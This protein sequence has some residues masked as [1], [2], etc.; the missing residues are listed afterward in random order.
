M[1]EVRFMPA[2]QP[3]QKGPMTAAEHRAQMV[4][5]AIAGEPRFALDM[6]E[7]ERGGPTYTI[8]TL[9]VQLRSALPDCA[10]GADHGLGPVRA[11]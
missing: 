1:D 2:A 7:I 6:H 4:Q 9:C 10:A 8:D 11:L 3:W 5:L